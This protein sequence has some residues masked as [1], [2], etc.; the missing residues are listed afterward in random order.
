MYTATDRKTEE[1]KTQEREYVE[2]STIGTWAV[3]T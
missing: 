3:A 2:R 1:W